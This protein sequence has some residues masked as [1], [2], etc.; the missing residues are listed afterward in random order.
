MWLCL[1]LGTPCVWA[2]QPGRHVM[3]VPVLG[4]HSFTQSAALIM[5]QALT[6]DHLLPC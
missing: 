1:V 2:H 6:D 5:V 4:A 3:A